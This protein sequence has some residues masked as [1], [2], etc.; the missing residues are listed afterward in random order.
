MFLP[1]I[2]RLMKHATLATAIAFSVAGGARADNSKIL[3]VVMHTALRILDPT[4]NTAYI[5]RDHGYMIYDT[6]FATDHNFEI[7]PQMVGSWNVSGDKLTYTFELRD[8]LK[9]HDGAPVT[10]DDVVASLERWGK[11][12]GMGQKLFSFIKEIA[13]TDQKGFKIVLKEPYGLVID[14]LGKIS[15][16]VPFIMPK[17]VAQR[18]VTEAITETVG[19]G[20]FRFVKSEFVPGVKAVYEKNPDYVP[21]SEPADGLTGGKVVKLDRV[22][23]IA[24]SDAQSAANALMSGEIDMFQ[25]PSY[26]L[27]PTLVSDPNV[28]LTMRNTTG[29]V[30]LMRMNWLQ[31][32]LDNVKI[33][34]AILHAIYEP[35]YLA[36]QVGN[37]EYEKECGSMFGCGTPL[38]TDVGAVQLKKPDLELAKKLLKEGDYNGEKI[39]VMYPADHPVMGPLAPVTVQALRNIGMNVEMQSTDWSTMMVRRTN[40]GSIEQGGWHIFHSGQSV[41][42]QM[43]PILNNY[44]KSPPKESG[45]FGWPS[46]EKIEQLRDKF[47]RETDPEKQKEIAAEIQ[48]RA[49]EVVVYIPLGIATRPIAHRK[50]VTGWVKAA[51]QVFWNVEK[52]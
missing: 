10:G 30:N 16:N 27:L 37:P 42:D 20:P 48:K 39:V 6:L 43:N 51:P 24:N 33:R 3:R 4:T 1:K 50:E 11:I 38:S 47:A 8:G 49:Y 26:D 21:R 35:D 19:S 29:D 23:W 44:L 52:H 36:A 5:A 14:S 31:P 41:P 32:P 13:P 34:Q 22:E 9:F 18:P 17:R 28:V 25:E 15:S 12:D 45:L 2:T 7:K 40:Q 46:D